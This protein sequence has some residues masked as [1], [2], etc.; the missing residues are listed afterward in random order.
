MFSTFFWGHYQ[1]FVWLSYALDYEWGRWWFGDPTRSTSYHFTSNLLHALNAALLYLLMLQLLTA[2]SAPKAP[3]PRPLCR[4]P[5]WP[6]HAAAALATL[7]FALHPLRVE[8]VAWATGRGDVL[9]TSF[10]LLTVL[11]YLRAAA[12]AGG[13]RYTISLVMA[14][15]LFSAALLTRAMAVTLPLILL[16]LDWYPLRRLG[17]PPKEWFA[18]S[19]RRIWFEKISFFALAAAAAVIAP[20]AKASVKATVGLTEHTPAQR[21]AQAC[22]GLV[23]YVWK[24]SVP[25]CLSPIYELRM[26]IEISEPR[27]IVSMLL[28]LFGAAAIVFLTVKRR[29]SALVC[30]ACA[31]ILLALPILGLVQSGNQEVADRYCYLPSLPLAILAAAGLRWTW[32]ALRTPVGIKLAL[33]LSGG[34]VAALLAVLTWRQCAIWHDA[35][36]LWKHAAL[37]SPDSSI[38]LNG[39]GWILVE[40]KRYEEA[41]PCLRRAIE[42]QPANEKAHHNLWRALSDQGRTDELLQAYRDSIRVFPAFFDARYNLGNELLAR[43]QNDEAA[44]EY[45]LA[46]SLKPGDSKA[47]ANL[48]KVLRRQGNIGEALREYDLAIKADPRNVIAR[49]GVAL[50]LHEQGRTTEAIEHLRAALAIDPSYEPARL[51]LD[52]WTGGSNAG[53]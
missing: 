8:P 45:R 39:Y 28:I 52:E 1:P 41:V 24:T 4:P 30:A 9:V 48:G 36:S 35:A 14:Y 40:Q 27:Y 51:L 3:S 47:H 18:R 6:L 21:L 46:L 11:A 17:R 53:R 22:Y 13:P 12:A 15:L 5:A 38:A 44:S 19:H 7:L 34:I 50:L 29:G 10:L 25:R 43:G 26:P 32:K 37:V 16:L 20:I 2:V 33:G 23:F 49:H 42:L 31:Y